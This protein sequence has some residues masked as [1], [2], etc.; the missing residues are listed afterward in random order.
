[1]RGLEIPDT[2]D[3]KAPSKL[4]FNRDV[5]APYHMW[6]DR[7]LSS[8]SIFIS[9]ALGHRFQRD[10]VSGLRLAESVVECA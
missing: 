6:I 3:R 2:I 4:V 7:H 1:M 5:V 10:G 8:T 9:Q